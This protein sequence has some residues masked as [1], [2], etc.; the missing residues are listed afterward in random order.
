MERMARKRLRD[1]GGIIDNLLREYADIRG[2]LRTVEEDDAE[3]V[4]DDVDDDEEEGEDDE[5][6]C[7]TSTCQT[8][9]KPVPCLAT[10]SPLLPTPSPL[11]CPPAPSP[12]PCPPIPCP[13]MTLPPSPPCPSMTLPPPCDT[14]ACCQPPTPSCKAPPCTLT[15]QKVAV[16]DQTVAF[17]QQVDVAYGYPSDSYDPNGQYFY[18]G[19]VSGVVF[20]GNST[21][22]DPSP[23]NVKAGFYRCTS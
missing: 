12:L 20:F 4:E 22:G 5:D 1:L 10:P 6:C 18:L 17:T 16:E 9:S 8:P 19:N 14:M 21:F 2:F 11:P 15:W 7:E 3:E 13:P 23:N